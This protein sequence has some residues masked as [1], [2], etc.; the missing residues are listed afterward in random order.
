MRRALP[1]LLALVCGGCLV[2]FPAP[3][4]EGDGG[5]IVAP[6]DALVARP[7]PRP[8][9]A[10]TPD[11]AAPT[12]N[13]ITVPATTSSR[14]IMVGIDATDNQAVTQMRLANEDGNWGTW[15]TFNANATHQLSAGYSI[16]GVYVQ[17]RDAAGNESSVIYRTLRYAA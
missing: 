16:K 4:D 14:T 2:E 11:A 5:P 10:P 1:T 13:A 15:T 6:V 12:L 17:V 9:A 7:A 3:A 8:D